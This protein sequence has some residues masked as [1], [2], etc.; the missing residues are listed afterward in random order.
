MFVSNDITYVGVNDRDCT[1][2]EGQYHVNGMCYNSYVIQDEKIAVM[3]TVD[4][5]CKDEWFDHLNNVL[6]QQ[7]PDYLII[8]HM[9][10]D[11]SANIANFLK[12]YPET[13]LVGNV[14]TF[15]MLD[16]FFT[17]ENTN[18]LVVKNNDTLCL[19]KHTL[20][21]VFAPMVHWPEVMVT[22]DSLDEV[23]F[24][25]DGFGKFG[26]NDSEEPWIDEAR[27]YYIGI[28]GKYGM[29]VTN[30][31]NKA[32]TLSIKTIC[33]LHGPVLSENLEYYIGLYKTWAS[34]SVEEDGIVI[35]YSSVYGNTAKA[36]AYLKELLEE[37]KQKVIMFDLSHD[38]M[39]EVIAQSF[40]YSKLVLASI[41]YNTDVF[42]HMHALIHGLVERNFQNRT[43]GFIENG[44]WAPLATKVMR[45]M[46]AN[47]KNITLLENN[48]TILSSMKDNNKEAL[49]AMA[50]ELSTK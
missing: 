37:R 17:L 8:Q 40:K 3:D 46:L 49:L 6:G 47:S 45:G 23:L 44:S 48:V 13:T 33:P 10:P 20:T 25:A 38:D 15:K 31:L 30:L 29:Q 28:C 35:A 14:S 1:L 36:C 26:T 22:Y 2:F 11:H 34:Y 18:R 43:I 32:S 39:S 27:R 19:G 21:F 24:S 12:V 7:K 9:E 41:T 5:H 16:Q 4:I 50:E 42:P